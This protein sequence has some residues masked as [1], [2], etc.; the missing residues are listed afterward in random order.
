[1]PMHTLIGPVCLQDM[2]MAAEMHAPMNVDKCEVSEDCLYLNITNPAW[3]R[4]LVCPSCYGF[5]V[6]ASHW[7][8]RMFLYLNVLNTAF[9]DSTY[10]LYNFLSVK[11]RTVEFAFPPLYFRDKKFDVMCLLIGNLLLKKIN[12][13]ERLYNIV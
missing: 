2:M 4:T 5:T 10:V 13:I 11:S 1:M 9:Y 12:N 3:P 8:R 7:V 6:V